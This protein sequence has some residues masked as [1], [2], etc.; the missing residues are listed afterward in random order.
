[1]IDRNVSRKEIEN[2]YSHRP[3]SG[4][5]RARKSRLFS[6]PVRPAVVTGRLS[7]AD[8]VGQ[9]A[10]MSIQA[11]NLGLC[12]KV[13]SRMVEDKGRPTVFLGLAGP[14]I[15]AGL[16]RVIRDLIV[17]GAVDAVVSTGAVLY[18]DI[19]QARGNRHY[20]GIVESDDGELRDLYIDRIYDT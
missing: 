13:L 12:G 10:G 16:R 5:Q 11:R 2:L 19:Y 8:L 15:A 17:S 4:R 3:L 20:Q 6:R 9:M 14:L 7:A 18:Q 1:M